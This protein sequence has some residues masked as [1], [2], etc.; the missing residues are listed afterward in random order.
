MLGFLDLQ[1]GQA[2]NAFF[3]E[4]EEWL[5][6]LTRLSS[7]TV[8]GE[9]EHGVSAYTEALLEQ[10]AESLGELQDIMARSE[11][12]RVAGN[13][14]LAGLNDNLALISGHMRTEQQVLLRI[15]ESQ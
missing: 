1:A 4:L 5:S 9:G 7:G 11:Q 10:T 13:Q 14:Q 8:S 3:N 6:G 2:Q 15:A 12:G